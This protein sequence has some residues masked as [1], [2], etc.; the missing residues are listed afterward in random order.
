MGK[1]LMENTAGK[2]IIEVAELSGRNKAEVNQIKAMLSRQS[3]TARMSYQEKPETRH[4]QF[5]FVGTVND[6]QYISDATG[7]RRFWPVKT[8][9]FN[10]KAIPNV[11]DQLWAEAS[12]REK[13]GESIQL[14]QELWK[15]AGEHQ[16]ERFETDPWEDVIRNTIES[17]YDIRS[18]G[19]YISR[20]SLMD[21]LGI[22]NSRKSRSDSRRI[23][24]IMQRL[25]FMHTTMRNNDT[26]AVVRGFVRKG[27][28][29]GQKL[30]E[31]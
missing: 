6:S 20:D 5:I 1:E 4:R 10:F 29:E 15:I 7:A 27:Y 21:S 12:F 13:A 9:K 28:K 8:K 3:D 25:K 11:R 24:D 2:W 22:E 16:E 26:G 31:S 14:R 18:E 17:V 23:S 19:L 30:W